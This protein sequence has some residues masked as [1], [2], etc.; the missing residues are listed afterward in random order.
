MAK[1]IVLVLALVS[2]IAGGL[3]AQEKSAAVKKFWLSG[4]VSLVG[5]GA[6]G[7]F[8]LTPKL[9]L[10]LDAY[11]TSLFFIFNEIGVNAE[12][13]FYPWGKKF[14]AGLGLGLGIHSGTEAMKGKWKIS[15]MGEGEGDGS[16]HVVTNTGFD[17]VPEIGWKIDIGKPGGFFIN[18]LAQ[19]PITIGEKQANYFLIAATQFGVSV[20]FRAACGFGWAF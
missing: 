7:E 2:M 12:A 3:A 9:S 6:R 1:K 4:E 16:L 5:A 13:R 14:Y 17:I 18:P 20:G 11:W 19:L 8:M 15:G 10:G